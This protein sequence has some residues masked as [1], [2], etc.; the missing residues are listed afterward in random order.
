M[1]AQTISPERRGWLISWARQQWLDDTRIPSFEARARFRDVAELLEGM[2]RPE[3]EP[4][5]SRPR[6]EVDRWHK[7]LAAFMRQQK[8]RLLREKRDGDRAGPGIEEEIE[9]ATSGAK[10]PS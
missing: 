10:Y 1:G 5:V 7:E 4:N 3:P 6:D 9:S 8:G 2:A